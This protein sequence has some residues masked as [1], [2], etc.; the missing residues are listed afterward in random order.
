MRLIRARRHTCEEDITERVI[1]AMSAKTLAVLMPGGV[2]ARCYAHATPPTCLCRPLRHLRCHDAARLPR[3]MARCYARA[4]ADDAAATMALMVMLMPADA[5]IYATRRCHAD[6]TRCFAQRHA[7]HARLLIRAPRH[8]AMPDFAL[9]QQPRFAHF[10]CHALISH[11]CRDA[12]LCRA[13]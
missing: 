13:P 6:A 9:F 8:A 1:S 4:R 2:A 12:E 10:R 5:D 7:R 3:H 11:I